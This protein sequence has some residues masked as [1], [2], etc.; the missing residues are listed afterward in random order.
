MTRRLPISLVFFL[1]TGIVMLLQLIPF[2]GIFLM[3]MLA[4]FW[5]VILINMGMVGIA[6]E[7]GIGRVSRAWLIVPLA[8][9]G[10]YYL[11]AAADRAA[12]AAL[13]ASYNASNAKVAIPF[14]PA[15]HALVFGTGGGNDGDGGG[16]GWFVQ[17]YALPVAYSANK[18]Y[19][20]GYRSS[21]LMPKAV[22]G[23]VG[24][25]QALRAAQVYTFGFHDGDAI[26]TRKMDARFCDLGM[27]E[28]PTLPV[29]R[30]TRLEETR[31]EGALPLRRVTTT[32]T[33]PDGRAHV[34]RGGTASPL[35]WFPMPAMGCGLNSGAP[36]WDCDAGFM[37]DSFTPIVEGNTRYSRDM[38]VLAEALGLKR[39]AIAHR[40]GGDETLVRAKLAQVEAATLARQL[41]ALDKMIADPLMRDPQWDLGVI[42]NRPEALLSRADAI[43]GGLERAA[44]VTGP[45]RWKARESGRI[46]AGL[47]AQLPAD[48]FTTYGARLLALYRAHFDVVSRDGDRRG[49]SH[50]LWETESLLRRLGNLGPDALFVA[51]DRRASVGNVNGAGIETMCRI[52]APGRAVAGPVLLARWAKLESH[53]RDERRDLFVALRRVGVAPP[54]FI[55]DERGQLA[56]LQKDW[57]DINPASPPRVCATR[58][59]KQARTEEKYGDK[60]RRTNRE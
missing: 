57:G 46:L 38:L 21:R 34:L 37:R 19:P 7:A 32:V 8:Y 11:F 33:M 50:W 47:I 26:G 14:D 42:G 39:V 58:A 25:S 60:R 12:L 10:G 49:E 59:E 1:V 22:C 40:R 56:E 44:T 52:G 29:V 5:S 41:A 23:E 36:S 30:V 9:F 16:G 55:D 4:M 24:G 35:K 51:I 2:I 27:P 28:R 43:M 18:N 48:C 3:L 53:D 54:P 13:S 31:S 15:R 17:N 45:D 20:E 6:I